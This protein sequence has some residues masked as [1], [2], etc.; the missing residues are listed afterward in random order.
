MKMPAQLCMPAI[1]TVRY[2]NMKLLDAAKAHYL[3]QA[4]GQDQQV[5]ALQGVWLNVS[6]DG[7]GPAP[8]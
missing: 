7:R 4:Q 3:H 1:A 8:V 2:A 6:V 5:Q